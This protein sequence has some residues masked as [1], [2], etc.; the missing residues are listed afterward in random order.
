MKWVEAAI[1]L[2]PLV[3]GAINSVQKLFEGKSGK[4][5]QDAAVEIIGQMIQALEIS[6][7]KELLDVPEFQVLL[8]KLIDDSVE[9]QNFIAKWKANRVLEN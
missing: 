4:D 2:L 1:K 9:I 5:K 7:D 8:R 6:I 3:A